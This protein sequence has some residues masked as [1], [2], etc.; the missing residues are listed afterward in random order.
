MI[1]LKQS[2]SEHYRIGQERSHYVTLCL[3][4]PAE[5]AH[6][7]FELIWTEMG[8]DRT[9]TGSAMEPL[10]SRGGEGV[11]FQQQDKRLRG[12]ESQDAAAWADTSCVASGDSWGSL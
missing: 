9:C 1:A 2:Q 8:G 5:T 11:L 12:L 10:A 3:G 4:W 6:L 7:C